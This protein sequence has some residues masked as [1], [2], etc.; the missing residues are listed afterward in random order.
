MH[1]LK[2]VLL[3]IFSS[4]MLSQDYD[5]M[6]GGYIR[7]GIIDDITELPKPHANISV[8]KA[9]SDK[10]VQG[11]VADE[12][13]LFFIDKIP[14]GIYYVVVE[15]VGYQDYIIDDVK[16]YPTHLEINLET[17]RL[18]SKA[19]IL[20]GVEVI[21]QMPVIE[22]IAKTTYPVA[23]TAR[24]EG[25]SADD[26]L[27][28]LPSVSIDVDGNVALRGNSNVTILID[29]RK[30]KMGVDMINANMI[31]KVEVMTTP[32]SKYDPDGI[33]GIIN[34]VLNKN[35]YVG[36]SGNVGINID[37]KKSIN[38]SGSLNSFNNDWNIF[39]SYSVKSKNKEGGGY[40]NTSLFDNAGDLLSSNYSDGLTD[41]NK[42]NANIK[43]GFE[44]YFQNS[45]L[46]AF[47]ITFLKYKNLKIENSNNTY[48][49]LDNASYVEELSTTLT[50]EED[51]GDDMNFGVG[52]FKNN[53]NKGSELSIQLDYEDHNDNEIIN[54]IV[55]SSNTSIKNETEDNVGSIFT[56]DY[57]APFSKDNDE[58]NFEVGLKVSSDIGAH[59]LDYNGEPFEYDYD[60][61]ITATYFNTTFGVTENFDMQ[62]GVRLEHQKKVTTLAY[63][64]TIDCNG[65]TESACNAEAAF[66]S[67][68]QSAST[69]SDSDF[70]WALDLVENKD[71]TYEHKEGIRVFPSIY[72]IYNLEDAGTIKLSGARRINR[73]WYRNLSPI[74]DISD[75]SVGIKFINVGNPLLLPEDILKSE[76][77]YSNKVSIG[78]FP[79]GFMKA[80][81]YYEDISDKIDRDK[82]T[83][84]EP[85]SNEVYQILSWKNNARSRKTGFE[86]MFATQM[87]KFSMRINGNWWNEKTWG[88]PDIDG[89]GTTHGFWGMLVGE[90]KL[91]NDQKISMYSHHSSPMKITTGTIK[92]FRRMDLTYKKEV[93]QRFN[94]TVKLKDVFDTGGFR[95][96]TDQLIYDDLGSSYNETLEADRRRD[97][98][99]LSKE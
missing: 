24:A 65:L 49:Y 73:P 10:I 99:T 8:V 9:D 63:D 77:Q 70:S 88:A 53:D 82:D 37:D 69:C 75:A 68:D 20:E 39:G 94:F 11:G 79:I 90:L 15:Y 27:E 56:L 19:L 17:I 59:D 60:N 31:E 14:Y 93:N 6:Q 26:V 74:P 43:L 23:E 80:A 36:Q 81:A 96:E 66:C 50:E 7:G 13:G 64:E 92:P 41:N 5:P 48:T 71:Y 84:V 72:F 30:S 22:D 91:K 87:Q 44:R 83:V 52:Y 61:K 51:K 3:F 45:D 98:R 57:S 25:G 97:N 34:I 54:Y 95:I 4:L 2:F 89:L 67:W 42:D 12:E 86:L 18:V 32:S 35:E 21:E 55:N 29:G 40:R 16:I 38:F 33:A 62:V 28:K 78:G 58:E 46:L 47:D 1:I 76:I 85:G